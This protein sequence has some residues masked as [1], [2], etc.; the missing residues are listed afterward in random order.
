MSSGHSRE[1]PF[2]TAPV[3]RLF[4]ANA[5][6]MMLVM[7]MN[8]LLSVVDAAFLGHFVGT[9]AL[10]AVSIVFPAVMILIALS[11]LVSG[12]MSSLLARQLGAG[13]Q[14]MAAAG[15]ARAHGLALFIALVLIVTFLAGGRIA[16]DHL[17]GTESDIAA[18]SY[19]FLLIL[20]CATPAQFLLGLHAD[21]CRNEGRAGMVALMSV[22]VTLANIAFNYVLIVQLDLGVAGSAWGTALAQGSG[23]ALLVGL[24]LRGVG[25]MP[26][27][28][29]GAHGWT[30]GWRLIMALGAPLSLSFIGIALVAAT[31]IATLRLTM[32]AGYSDT[33]A[34][35]G[36]VTR[37]FGFTFLPLMAIALAMQSIVGNNVGAGLYHRLDAAL[38][39]AVSVSF[40]YCAAVEL[41]LSVSSGTIGAGFVQDEAVIVEVG[42]IL[43]P[44]VLFYF[45]TGPILMLALYFQAVGQP[46]RASALTLIKP[47]VFSP[48]LIVSFGAFAGSAAIWLAFPFADCL[49]A[50]LAATILLPLVKGRTS[51]GGFGLKRERGAA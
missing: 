40:L 44:M 2:L 16:V 38:R 6:P 45:F 30:G 49:L 33:V 1:N 27:A 20:I 10:A 39:L 17:V 32:D 47:F 34:A 18:M 48:V 50:A 4:V 19:T 11:A 13:R 7:L 51:Q 24:R 43:R 5:L 23:L 37:I 41:L 9:E 31:V 46:V 15:F 21:A 29:L 35:Y 3:G 22:G 8:G 14:D 25:M 12:G 28:S 36:V 42:A 26:L